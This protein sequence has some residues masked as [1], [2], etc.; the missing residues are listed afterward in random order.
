MATVPD[1]IQQLGGV[2]AIANETGI[3]LTTVHSWKRARFVPAWR[4]PALVELAAR[5]GCALSDQDF[6]KERPA[7]KEAA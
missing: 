1:I 3:P 2:T 4:V 5:K 6:P 7:A